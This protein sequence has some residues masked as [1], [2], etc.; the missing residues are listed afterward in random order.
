M[1][2]NSRDHYEI[3]GIFKYMCEL[4]SNLFTIRM[5]ITSYSFIG[6][7]AWENRSYQYIVGINMKNMHGV[8][9]FCIHNMHH[10]ILYL[11]NWLKYIG[12]S[13]KTLFLC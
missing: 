7:R 9:I 3:Y 13:M 8:P 11:K 4:K 5:H 12:Y 10:N 2:L 1:V 6:D